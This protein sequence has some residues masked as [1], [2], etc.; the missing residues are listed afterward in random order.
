M[1]LGRSKRNG[2]M[3]FGTEWKYW[4]LVYRDN[5]NLV[6]KYKCLVLNVIKVNIVLLWSLS[7]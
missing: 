2:G 7:V 4:C 3:G 5:V 6:G 1:P